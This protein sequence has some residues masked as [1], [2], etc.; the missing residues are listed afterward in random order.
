M[1]LKR[2]K[3]KLLIVILLALGVF[4]YQY[5]TSIGDSDVENAAQLRVTKKIASSSNLVFN[6]VKITQKSEFKEGVSYRVCGLYRL[7]SNEE[8]QPFI[9]NIGVQDGKFSEHDQLIVSETPE[10]RLA[11][12]NLCQPTDSQK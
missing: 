11:I 9:A 7:E 2:I 10:L 8:Y 4:S 3:T 1:V 6:D 5:Y 12:E